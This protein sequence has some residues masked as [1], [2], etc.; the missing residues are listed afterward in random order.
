[1]RVIDEWPLKVGVR[2]TGRTSS[3]QL[4]SVKYL[5]SS[6]G[7]TKMIRVLRLS[8]RLSLPCIQNN[9]EPRM[10]YNASVILQL[11]LYTISLFF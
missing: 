11:P 5:S 10:S 1:M 3:I 9:A 4:S 6:P 2:Y 7:T 8:L